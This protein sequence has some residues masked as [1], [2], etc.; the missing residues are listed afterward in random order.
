[1]MHWYRPLRRGLATAAAHLLGCNE[2]SP[3]HRRAYPCSST[4][5]GA[6]A[7]APRR[8]RRLAARGLIRRAALK[9]GH[10]ITPRE[11]W[12]RFDGGVTMKLQGTTAQGRQRFGYAYS[13][14]YQ[15]GR[16]GGL[17]RVGS[18]CGLLGALVAC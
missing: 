6:F 9:P 17:C 14:A 1:M 12:P 13:Q 18:L 4:S 16:G 11:T 7:G 5:A 15:V 10:I 8:V 3:I 2:K